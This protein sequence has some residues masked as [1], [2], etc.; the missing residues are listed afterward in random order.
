MYI[1]NLTRITSRSTVK[2]GVTIVALPKGTEDGLDLD[3]EKYP[4]GVLVNVGFSSYTIR[5]ADG[6]RRS[7]LW[8][9]HDM[10]LVQVTETTPDV[11][12]AFP[13]PGEDEAFDATDMDLGVKAGRAA[14]MGMPGHPGMRSPAEIADTAAKAAVVIER[15]RLAERLRDRALWVQPNEEN[16]PAELQPAAQRWMFSIATQIEQGL[17]VKTQQELDPDDA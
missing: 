14:V 1:R 12:P 16:L 10:Y 6:H 8:A 17:P 5:A 4:M 2:P 9:E 7:L 13:M 15:K 11:A 3:L